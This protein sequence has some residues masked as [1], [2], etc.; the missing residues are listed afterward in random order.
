MID[1]DIGLAVVVRGRQPSEMF[2]LA[3]TYYR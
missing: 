1:T 3:Q 2:P